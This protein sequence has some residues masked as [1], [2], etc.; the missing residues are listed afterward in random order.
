MAH[1]LCD[2]YTATAP[3]LVV[4][5]AKAHHGLFFRSNFKSHDEP[6]SRLILVNLISGGL[7]TGVTLV[8]SQ[9]TNSNVLI[10]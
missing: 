8:V 5:R 1:A 4:V 10:L 2:T 3:M 7:V 9:E 6:C